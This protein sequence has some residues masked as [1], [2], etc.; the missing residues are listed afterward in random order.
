MTRAELIDRFV[1][2]AALEV[3]LLNLPGANGL[4]TEDLAGSEALDDIA[5]ELS[6]SLYDELWPPASLDTPEER[7][8]SARID[9]LAARLFASLAG[10][11]DHLSE[12]AAYFAGLA[13]TR[14][15]ELA[16][17]GS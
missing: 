12:K 11:S 3:L 7:L 1:H 17:A 16:E 8:A 9:A 6:A 15:R 4:A 13:D 5:C 10:D 14:M 2:R